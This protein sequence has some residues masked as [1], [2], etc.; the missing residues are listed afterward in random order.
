MSDENDGNP[1]RERG[2]LT[3]IRQRTDPC[4][5]ACERPTLTRRVTVALE[6]R[7]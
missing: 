1:K 7:K 4:A 3:R 2:T 5:N 6:L